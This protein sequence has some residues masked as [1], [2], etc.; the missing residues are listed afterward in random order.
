MS[1]R[2]NNNPRPAY[3]Q[4]EYEGEQVRSVLEEIGLEIEGETHSQFLLFCPFHDNSENTAFAIGKTNGAY[5]C[6]N[7]SCQARGNLQQLVK[8]LAGEAKPVNERVEAILS[9]TPPEPYDQSKLD[10]LHELFLGSRTAQEY[11]EWRGIGID[12]CKLFEIGY[13]PD[14]NMIAVPVHSHEGVPVGIVGRTCSKTDKRFKNSQGLPVATEMFNVNRARHGDGTVVIL[15]SSFDAIRL[16]QLGWDAVATL[17]G[18]FSAY[19]Q[20]IINKYFTNVIL[21]TDFDD[22]IIHEKC[23][24]CG[25]RCKGHNPGRAL[26]HKIADAL[27]RKNVRWAFYDPKAG[28]LHPERGG[29]LLKDAGS[30][31]DKEVRAC[32]VNNISTMDYLMFRQKLD[33]LRPL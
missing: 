17:G 27:P 32:L 5:F 33:Y 9:A 30:M 23:S 15:E 2:G 31:S 4:V 3:T 25:R 19:H 10:K 28:L 8:R 16:K 7:P 13:N 22:L 26:A 11:M 6:F 14:M 18:S 12:T 21:F 20:A 29:K 1:I 24:K